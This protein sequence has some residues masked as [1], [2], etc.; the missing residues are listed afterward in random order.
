MNTNDLDKNFQSLLH[1]PTFNLP[2]ITPISHWLSGDAAFVA[3]KEA[4]DELL[5][6]KIGVTH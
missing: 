3:L 5:E 4:V 6:G 2:K 1:P